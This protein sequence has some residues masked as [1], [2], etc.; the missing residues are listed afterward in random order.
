[1]ELCKKYVP[2]LCC[3]L[4]K[5]E[6]YATY[7]KNLR[8]VHP[9]MIQKISS[10]KSEYKMCAKY[11]KKLFLLHLKSNNLLLEQEGNFSDDTD[12]GNEIKTT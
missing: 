9:W 8:N 10:L 1:V 12:S 4:F 2:T 6:G 5:D 3:N 7:R 11:R